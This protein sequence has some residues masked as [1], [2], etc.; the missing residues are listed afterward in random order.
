MAMKSQRRG[1]VLGCPRGNSLRVE[2]ER[3]Q[4]TLDNTA[5]TLSKARPSTESGRGKEGYNLVGRWKK[6]A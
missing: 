4:Q 6:S 3:E 2:M 5:N 1:H